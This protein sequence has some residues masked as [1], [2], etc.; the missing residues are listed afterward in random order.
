MGKRQ[1]CRIEIQSTEMEVDGVTEASRI[2]WKRGSRSTVVSGRATNLAPALGVEVAIVPADA[3]DGSALSFLAAE[4]L[5][6]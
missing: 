2:Y 1:A 3:P 5:R 4:P 6:P